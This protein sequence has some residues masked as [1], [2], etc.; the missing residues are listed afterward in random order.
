MFQQDNNLSLYTTDDTLPAPTFAH[1]QPWATAHGVD[2]GRGGQ[3]EGLPPRPGQQDDNGKCDD[4]GVTMTTSAPPSTAASNGEGD[5]MA[6]RWSPRPN[7]KDMDEITD[8]TMQERNA[9][10][11]HPPLSRLQR[12][13]VFFF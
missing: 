1:S 13:G 5:G 9:M 11:P 7:D 2:S 8:T 3:D 4:K 10:T 6:T 12:N